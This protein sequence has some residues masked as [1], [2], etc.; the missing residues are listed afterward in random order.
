MPVQAF[1]PGGNG[2]GVTN[3]S[4]G[5]VITS[6]SKRRNNIKRISWYRGNIAI[7]FIHAFRGKYCPRWLDSCGGTIPDCMRAVIFLDGNMSN[8]NI[9]DH[10]NVL[11]CKHNPNHSLKE[12]HYNLGNVLKM[13]KREEKGTTSSTLPLDVCPT[14]TIYALE[15]SRLKENGDLN[16]AESKMNAIRDVIPLMSHAMTQSS[17]PM[18]VKKVFF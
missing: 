15:L 13:H 6:K 2:D 18:R 11:R 5:Y 14:K 8:D 17:A 16:L 4:I 12:K 1:C 7:P 3:T 10:N 9:C